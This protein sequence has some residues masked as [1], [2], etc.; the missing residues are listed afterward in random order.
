MKQYPIR[1][2]KQSAALSLLLLSAC[3]APPP[4][5]LLT[6][7]GLKDDAVGLMRGVILDLHPGV[8][9]AD[10]THEVRPF[11]VRQGARR[12]ADAPGFYPDGSVFVVVIDPGVGTARRA[13]VARLQN[14][15]MIVAPDNGVATYA[16]DR[17]RPAVVREVTNP[18]L[19]LPRMSATFHGRDLFAPVGGHL[20]AGVPFDEVGP[21]VTD[22]IRL[23]PLVATRTGDAITGQ[24]LDIDEP[25]GNVWTNVPVAWL[26]DLGVR[27]GDTLTVT[28]GD[29]APM[30]MPFLRTFG[31]VAERTPLAYENS[32]GSTA[33]ALNLGDFARTHGVEPDQVVVIQR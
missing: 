21:I 15:S 16:I 2:L 8:V 6:D 29:G 22:W 10:L 7:F 3:A 20:A 12:L 28:F 13:I 4:V 30:K 23:E 25:F 14:G 11:D 27:P 9:I 1:L 33:F 17:H 19:A 24:V 18:D 31:E 26:A 32:R 5:V